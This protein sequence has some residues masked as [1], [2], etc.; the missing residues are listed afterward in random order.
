MRRDFQIRVAFSPTRSS[1]DRL[2]LAYEFVS[3]AIAQPVVKKNPLVARANAQH[4]RTH[5]KEQG[6]VSK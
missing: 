2:R 5:N 6:S 1:A 3:P 4:T